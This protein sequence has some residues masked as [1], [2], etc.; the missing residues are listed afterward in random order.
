M[1]CPSYVDRVWTPDLDDLGAPLRWRPE[2][3]RCM[4]ANAVRKAAGSARRPRVLVGVDPSYTMLNH[5]CTAL[6]EAMRAA[7]A[8]DFL[9]IVRS[10]DAMLDWSRRFYPHDKLPPN[11]LL[12]VK[13]N[14]Q[15]ELD[16]RVPALLAC[17]AAKRVL[18]ADAMRGPLDLARWLAMS[19]ACEDCH[20]PVQAGQAADDYARRE[21][22]RAVA[23]GSPRPGVGLM[24]WRIV[25]QPNGR[26]A[27]FSDI[28]DTFT[29]MNMTRTDALMLCVD[30]CGSKMARA[31]VDGADADTVW[32][33]QGDGSG[34][35]RWRDCLET[36]RVIHGEDEER[37]VREWVS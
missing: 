22:H 7:T 14:T 31:K 13:A 10:P 24:G 21:R 33:E 19:E 16:A 12:G 27:R 25:K 11:V 2:R 1:K 3:W 26:Y 35:C 18:V 36:I 5:E 37:R 29:H 34:L 23:S 20:R 15:A 28:V 9:V 32:G 17:P 8:V 30:M 4:F 6:F